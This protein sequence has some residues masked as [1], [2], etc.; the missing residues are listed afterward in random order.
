MMG[1]MG[2]GL[3]LN[4]LLVTMDGVDNPP[5][6]KKFWTNR[7]NS[8]FD[9]IYIVPRRVKKRMGLR[10]RGA[11]ST[12]CGA[13]LL[14]ELPPGHGR[15]TTPI[16]API[17]ASAT[18]WNMIVMASRRSSWS[19]GVGSGARPRAGSSAGKTR[20]SGTRSPTRSRA[21]TTTTSRSACRG[22]SRPATRST[23]SAR[24]TSRSTAL[25]P[26]LTRP[27]RMGRHVMVPDA[28]QGGPEGHL[29]PV[30]RQGRPRSVARHARA[31]RRDRPHHERL[32]AGD[33]RPDLL[34]GAHGRPPHGPRVLHLGRPRRRDDRDRVGHGRQRHS[35]T[36]RT[37]ARRRSTRPGT[38]R[39]RT[40]TAPRSSRAGSRS[41]CAAGSLGH[42]S[43]LRE[44]RAVREVWQ[45]RSSAS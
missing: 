7:A 44:G 20:S 24:R 27:G 6:W 36:R 38:R 32:L 28:D 34:D 35:I 9:A 12:P 40:S 37:P 41:G 13:F 21:T 25:D 17:T 5:F 11:A 22:P 15:P 43:A 14:P 3:A 26:A 23:S 19:S 30:P 33:D 2:V 31:A 1:G 4:Q 18:V 29:R 8:F 39:R 16:Y 45:Q 42:H 10:G